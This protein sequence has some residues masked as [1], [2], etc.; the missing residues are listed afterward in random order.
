[1]ELHFIPI[2][3]EKVMAHEIFKQHPGAKKVYTVGDDVFLEAHYGEATE[4]ATRHGLPL[5]EVLNPNPTVAG[6]ELPDADL[7]AEAEAN[8]SADAEVD[9]DMAEFDAF[10]AAAENAVEALEDAADELQAEL[11]KE[12]KKAGKK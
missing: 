8:Q 1:V 7:E 12:G 9:P 2:Q 3:L 11:P 10:V 4:Y 5:K 6:E